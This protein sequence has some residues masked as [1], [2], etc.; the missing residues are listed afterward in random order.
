MKHIKLLISIVAATTLLDLTGGCVNPA[1]VS[2]RLRTTLETNGGRPLVVLVRTSDGG[3]ATFRR[4]NY[5]DLERLAVAPDRSVLRSVT[6]FPQSQ[7]SRCIDFPYQ[8][9]KGYAIYALY[10]EIQGDWKVLYEPTAPYRLELL[11]GPRGIDAGRSREKR[12]LFSS[13]DASLPTEP[14]ALD[15]AAT[16]AK[17]LLSGVQSGAP[18]DSAPT[19]PMNPIAPTPTMPPNNTGGNAP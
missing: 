11:L 9:R 6:V 7:A 19:P 5:A 18:G 14:S 13:R 12:P 1:T 16:K 3:A 10:A 15:A 4:E 8:R 2:V 17:A